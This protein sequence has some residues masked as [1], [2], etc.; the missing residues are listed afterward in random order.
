MPW[1]ALTKGFETQVSEEHHEAL[2]AWSWCAD[3]RLL[4]SGI[5]QVYAVRFSRDENG[6][7]GKLYMHREIVQPPEGYVV[8]HINGDTLDN[9]PHNLRLATAGQNR[10]NVC[11]F[12]SSKYVGV[13]RVRNRWRSRIERINRDTGKR[14]LLFSS[15]FETEQEAARAR[16]L[17]VL[18]LLGPYARLNFPLSDYRE[19]PRPGPAQADSIPF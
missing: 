6:K 3:V 11:G 14:E 15:Y 17:K 5:E 18:E 2:R 12:G 10:E 8:D 1:I 9:R 16:D 19:A 4:G 13:T 7:T